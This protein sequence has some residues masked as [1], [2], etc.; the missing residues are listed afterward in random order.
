MAKEKYNLIQELTKRSEMLTNEDR[1][2]LVGQGDFPGAN[3]VMRSTMNI[4]HHTQHLTIDNPEFPMFYDGKENV[5]GHH[6]KFYIQAKK[7]YRVDKIIKK[8]DKLLNGKSKFALYF[9]HC[10]EDDSWELLERKEV[11]NLTQNFGFDY[12]TD[13]VD[14][15]EEGD[16]IPAGTTMLS[17]TSYDEYGNTGIGVNG[18]IMYAVHPAVVEDAII[19]SESFAKRLVT[20]NVK[21]VSIPVSDNTILLNLYGTKDDYKGLPDIGT[22]I[23]DGIVAATRTI[24]EGRMFSDL[25]DSSLSMTNDQNDVKYY[26]IGMGEVIDIDIYCNNPDLE[27]N[28][29]NKQIYQYYKDCRWFYTDVY[30][31]CKKILNSSSNDIDN[32]INYWMKKAQDYL[33][34]DESWTIHDDI[35]SNVFINILIRSKEEAR[36]GRKIVGEA[37]IANIKVG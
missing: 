35:Y 21:L 37:V 1:L 26:D 17:S 3:N 34:D 31:E 7:P 6:S 36:V 10:E 8:Y 2:A 5:S 11:E 32:N 22:K 14:D 30:K 16:V 20:N 28:K 33:N 29:V 13:Y 12:N 9:L 25:R 27:Y 23:K 4:K 19:V 18:R 24:K 15:L